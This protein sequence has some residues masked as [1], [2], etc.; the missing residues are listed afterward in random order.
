MDARQRRTYAR[1]ATAILTLASDGPVDDVSVSQLAATTGVH[2]STVYEYA[3]SP[4]Q[5]LARILGDELDA[6]R[7]AHLVGV[8]PQSAEAAIAAVTRDVL[9][10]VDEHDAI[11][12]RGLGEES[13]AASLHALLS[14]HF[15]GSIR[16]LLDQHSV[17][18]PARTDLDREM[19]GRYLADGIIGVIAVWLTTP[20]PRDIDSV[21][22][23]L[24][25]MT[26]DWW[27][28]G[29]GMREA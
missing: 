15:R 27:P 12:A 11:Y 26:P 22:E 13:G 2:R 1:L 14:E 5:L 21:L 4:V 19:I 3:D 8:T 20:R 28:G 16:L 17:D 29:P 7:A 23:L 24:T 9:R 6:L 10:H 25:T 18:V